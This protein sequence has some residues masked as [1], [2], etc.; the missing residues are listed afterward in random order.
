MNIH[1]VRS[2]KGGSGKTCFALHKS[3]YLSVGEKDEKKVLY[4]DADVHASETM[5]MMMHKEAGNLDKVLNPDIH[6]CVCFDK[7]YDVFIKD[8]PHTLNS[9]MHP[10]RGYISNFKDIIIAGK[11]FNAKEYKDL[12]DKASIRSSLDFIFADPTNKGRAVFENMYQSSG[13]SAIGLGLYVAKMKTLLRL[14]ASHEYDDIVIDMPPGSDTFSSHLM[15]CATDFV[16]DN[17][18]KHRLHVYYVAGSDKSHIRS[19]AKAAIEQHLHLMRK[20][21][22]CEVCF[23][24][25]NV[26]S[27]TDNVNSG[28]GEGTSGTGKGTG[29]T[30]P[31]TCKDRADFIKEVSELIKG[32]YTEAKLELNRLSYYVIE[33]D[34]PYYNF[35]RD[36]GNHAVVFKDATIIKK[37]QPEDKYDD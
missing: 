24:F 19:S 26:N 6:T 16:S 4:I 32:E 14:A 37:L 8:S 17:D 15:D 30:K 9:Y 13:T 21:T 20:S 22:P 1:V 18:S 28:T 2:V 34:A 5:S 35:V 10:Y 12:R 7:D 36:S 3:V 25:N 23:V 33:K 31:I 29:G 27:D 11:V